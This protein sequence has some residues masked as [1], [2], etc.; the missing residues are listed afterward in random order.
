MKKKRASPK[1]KPKGKRKVARKSPAASGKRGQKTPA[2]P[3]PTWR[4]TVQSAIDTL[5]RRKIP[6]DLG[7]IYAEVDLQG[8]RV[9]PP[10]PTHW[11]SKVRQTLQSLTSGPNPS[12]LRQVTPPRIGQPRIPIPGRFSPTMAAKTGLPSDEV[13]AM[14]IEHCELA[15]LE[16]SETRHWAHP[17]HF[18][19]AHIEHSYE[20]S[21]VI[22]PDE[23]G[24]LEEN[25]TEDGII[26]LSNGTRALA[27]WYGEDTAVQALMYH[28]I[29]DSDPWSEWVTLVYALNPQV[30]GGQMA[31]AIDE[32]LERK[33]LEVYK[34]IRVIEAMTWTV[35]EPEGNQ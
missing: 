9:P 8:L 33:G 35:K 10:L 25:L 17:S 7:R 26:A 20:I 28:V 22:A 21:F 30:A 11:K 3:L 12:I 31:F 19:Q 32:L 6:L 5:T 2:R 4:A 14:L 1:R 16:V 13:M 27:E 34:L 29:R 15:G 23:D 18:M 24:D